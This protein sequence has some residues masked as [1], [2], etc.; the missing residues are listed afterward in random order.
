M[1]KQRKPLDLGMVLREVSPLNESQRDVFDAYGEQFNLFL[2]GVAGTGKT[3]LGLYLGLRDVVARAYDRLV[4]VR[5]AVAARDIGHLPGTAAEK[6]AAYETPYVPMV[7]S[8][9]GRKDAYQTLVQ[10]GLL[11]FV[12]TSYMRG[13]TLDNCVIVADEIQNCT[14]QE[15]DTLITRVGKRCRVVLCGDLLQTDL[16]RSRNDVTGF[17]TFFDIVSDMPEFDSV[18]FG[19]EDI[20]RSGLV[21]SYILAKLRRGE[22]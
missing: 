12:S 16:L 18:E 7:A 8:L 4:V 21:K 19:P 3:Y 9:F 11:E 20:V 5:S 15:L 22:R 6:M 1:A 17:G 13:I 2:Y 10:K 14:F